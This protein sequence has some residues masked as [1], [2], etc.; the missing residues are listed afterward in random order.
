MN[1][2]AAVLPASA[3]YDVWDALLTVGAIF[4]LVMWAWVMITILID[5]FRDHSLSG[6]WKAVWVFFLIFVPVITALI[7]LIA[8]G[9]GMQKRAI[10]AQEQARQATEAYIRGV[11]GGG[12]GGASPVDELQRLADLR[13]RG[14]ISDEEYAALKAKLID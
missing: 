10:A 8:R 3:A 6:G 12:A 5:L 2:I 7:Y 11:A 1:P 13:E 14:A 9:G 4:L